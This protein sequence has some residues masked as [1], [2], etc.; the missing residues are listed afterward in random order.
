MRRGKFLKLRVSKT[1]Q[2]R[3]EEN[4][5]AAGLT[6]S[7]YIRQRTC[8]ELGPA[9]PPARTTRRRGSDFEQRV[10]EEMR[11]MPKVNAER[12]VRRE[13][14]REKAREALGVVD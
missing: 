14:A 10:R 1:E 2:A 6:V 13:E 4:A 12:L 5:E 7:E 9:R 8:G 3:I 11:T